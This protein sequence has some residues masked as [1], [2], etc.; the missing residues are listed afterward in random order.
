MA[1][2]KIYGAVLG[3]DGFYTITYE[4]PKKAKKAKQ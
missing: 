2:K 1:E 4:A 3:A